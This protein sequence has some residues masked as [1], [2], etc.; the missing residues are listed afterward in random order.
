MLRQG[1]MLRA[2]RPLRCFGRNF[3]WRDFPSDDLVG[4]RLLCTL[5][6]SISQMGEKGLRLYWLFQNENGDDE[7]FSRF[8][9]RA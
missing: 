1:W 8:R 7:F 9:G 3:Y 5:P 2:K 4:L 6:E